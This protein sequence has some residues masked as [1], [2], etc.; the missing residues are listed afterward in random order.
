MLSPEQVVITPSRYGRMM[1][2]QNDLYV[3]RSFLRYGEFSEGE[4]ALWKTLIKPGMVVCDIGANIGAHTVALASLVGPTGAVLSFEPIPFLFQMLCG[5][6]ALNALTNVRCFPYALG[7]D[8]GEVRI[9]PIDFGKEDNFGGLSVD[10]F[11]MGEPVPVMPFDVLRL[12]HIEFMKI[13]VEGMERLVLAGARQTIA[14]FT[15]ILYVENDRSEKSD[16]LVHLIK[17]LGY[18]CFWHTPPLF[19]PENF[20]QEAENV[21]A[22]TISVNM[23]CVPAGVKVDGLEPIVFEDA[24]IAKPEMPTS[25]TPALELES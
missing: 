18:D 7:A 15:P 9:P 24:T 11:P 10:Q 21:F 14:R 12:K 20:K 3:G 13:D 5:N 2:L 1:H 8:H 16:A 19:N 22:D 4:V 25:A 6:V 17:T 23:L